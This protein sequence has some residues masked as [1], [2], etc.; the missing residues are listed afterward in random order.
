MVKHGGGSIMWWQTESE[1]MKRETKLSVKN[2]LVQ[3]KLFF[4]DLI[5][6]L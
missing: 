4:T 2:N 3:P 6:P 1:L 5:H